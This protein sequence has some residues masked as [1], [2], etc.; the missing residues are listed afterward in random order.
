MIRIENEY[1]LLSKIALDFR[2]KCRK[3]EPQVQQ[4]EYRVEE[5]QEEMAIVEGVCNILARLSTN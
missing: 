4:L 5:T 3:I 2:M 1:K